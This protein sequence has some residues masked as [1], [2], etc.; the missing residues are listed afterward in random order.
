MLKSAMPDVGREQTPK[1]VQTEA[2]LIEYFTKKNADRA[3]RKAALEAVQTLLTPKK[4]LEQRNLEIA[5]NR[6]V[7]QP[8]SLSNEHISN[9]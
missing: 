5:S 1:Q 7:P 9:R 8:I 2:E 6:P 3:A 4:T